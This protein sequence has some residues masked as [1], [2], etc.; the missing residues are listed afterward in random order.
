MVLDKELID[1]LGPT[2]TITDWSITGSFS[3]DYKLMGM[4]DNQGQVS[5]V[6]LAQGS[7]SDLISVKN[8]LQS[9]DLI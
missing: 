1:S 8:D 5:S 7:I 4:L 2:R 9:K 3:G 6:L